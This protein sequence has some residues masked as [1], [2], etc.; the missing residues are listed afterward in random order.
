M[1]GDE[2]MVTDEEIVSEMNILREKMTSEKFAKHFK[3]WN[4]TM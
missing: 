3:T 1:K 4:K 2:E